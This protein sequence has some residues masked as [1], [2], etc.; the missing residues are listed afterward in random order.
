ME[1]KVDRPTATVPRRLCDVEFEP[2]RFDA[3]SSQSMITDRTGSLRDRNRCGATVYFGIARVRTS[4]STRAMKS[5]T[6][7]A[8]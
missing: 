8:P 3:F 5:A 2:G 7:S 6:V 4:P 1:I